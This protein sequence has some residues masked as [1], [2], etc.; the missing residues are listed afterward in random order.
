MVNLE[1]KRFCVAQEIPVAAI[2]LP[3]ACGVLRDLAVSSR[4]CYVTVT[5]AHG[6]VESIA[7]QRV[8][9]AHAGAD[10]IVPDGMLLVWLGRALG[11]TA[12]DR[13]YG[14]DLMQTIFAD[15]YCR[16]LRHFFYGSRPQVVAKLRERMAFKF[17]KFNDSGFHCP[18]MCPAGF[19]EDTGVLTKIQ[20]ARPNR[21][22]ERRVGKECRSRR[23]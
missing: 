5:G 1:F 7:D 3:G 21:S 16:G 9:N 12:I 23:S 8:R 20:K 13:V 22:E 2:N 11:Y 17:G 19:L 18:D 14:P 6:I 10:L 4:G 15:A